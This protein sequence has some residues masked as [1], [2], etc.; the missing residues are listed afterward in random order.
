MAAITRPKPATQ[1]KRL[2]FLMEQAGTPIHVKDVMGWF[3]CS[4]AHAYNILR[5]IPVRR[6]RWG[7]YERNWS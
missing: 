6:V 4:R 7:Y 1:A 5:Q 2:M 3:R